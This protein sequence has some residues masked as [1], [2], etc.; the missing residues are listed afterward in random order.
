M[1]GGVG[2]PFATHLPVLLGLARLHKIERVLEF[3]GGFYSTLTFLDHSAFPDLKV[4]HCL[5]DDPVWAESLVTRTNGD[6]RVTV[7]KV[8]ATM[9]SAASGVR[10]SDYDLVLVDDSTAYSDRAKTI[11]SISE[12]WQGHNLL[13]MH[14]YEVPLYK[15]ASRAFANRFSFTALLPNTGVAWNKA[16]LRVEQLQDLNRLLSDHA[17]QIPPEDAAE[18]IR[19][20]EASNSR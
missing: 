9:V 4:L 18:W 6:H 20:I 2:D 11:Q 17:K 5:E 8:E 13:V 7:E 15:E 10:F 19:I 16:P 3:G 1:Y 14:D 12:R